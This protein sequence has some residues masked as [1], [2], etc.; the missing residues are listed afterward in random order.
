MIL[1]EL[2]GFPKN[3]HKHLLTFFNLTCEVK[4]KYIDFNALKL[5]I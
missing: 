2:S 5:Y 4:T 3:K 1:T